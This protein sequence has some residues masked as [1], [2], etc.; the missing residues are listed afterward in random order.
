MP[1]TAKKNTKLVTTSVYGW[2]RHPMQTGLL[3]QMMFGGDG[4]YTMER[5]LWVV[6]MCSFIFIGVEMEERRLMKSERDYPDYCQ[7]V[8]G[9]FIPFL[10]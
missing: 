7:K 4:N 6:I 3:L 8:K 10:L 1:Y 2:M 5:L 9:R